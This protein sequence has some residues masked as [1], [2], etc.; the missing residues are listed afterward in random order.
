MPVLHGFTFPRLCKISN[1]DDAS[2]FQL[3]D[4]ILLFITMRLMEI[5]LHETMAWSVVPWTCRLGISIARGM[6][7]IEKVVLVPAFQKVP[8]LCAVVW[9]FIKQN[10]LISIAAIIVVVMFVFKKFRHDA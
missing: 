5:G 4:T 9:S 6:E 10:P 7:S 3:L 2:L 1:N 8:G